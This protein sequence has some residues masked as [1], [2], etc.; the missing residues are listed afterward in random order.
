MAVLS[1][2]S[3]RSGKLVGAS[4]KDQPAINRRAVS[5]LPTTVK[6][7]ATGTADCFRELSNLGLPD[8]NV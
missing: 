8:S 7:L 4:G 1:I 2:I 5:T 6:Y 3:G